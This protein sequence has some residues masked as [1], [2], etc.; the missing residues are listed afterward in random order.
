MKVQ[1]TAGTL[2]GTPLRHLDAGQIVDMDVADVARLARV[3][4]AKLVDDDDRD[5]LFAELR[6]QDAR[7]FRQSEARR[8]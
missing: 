2:G 6:R 4:K 3:G 5:S 7:V 8:S 1:I